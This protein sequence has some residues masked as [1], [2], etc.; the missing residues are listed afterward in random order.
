MLQVMKSKHPITCSMV[1]TFVLVV[2]AGWAS[3]ATQP[4]G[5][6][7]QPVPMEEYPIYDEVIRNKFLTSHTR[8][9]IIQRLTV[10][11][12]RPFQTHAPDR[13]FIQENVGFSN[14]LEPDLIADFLLKITRPS[15]LQGRF[16]FG[17]PVRFAT[18][19]QL[20]GPEVSLRPIPVQALPPQGVPDPPHT[21]GVLEFSRV[22]FDRTETQALVYVGVDRIDET[23]A[24][25]LIWLQ[26]AGHAWSVID[27]E[28]L[29]IRR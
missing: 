8:L 12:L 29:W 10:T 11:K 9:V 16:G 13:R 28:I 15:R 7:S 2:S 4:K 26:G 25:F 21:V 1:A 20:E 22:G 17:V 14:F 27:T 5:E 23:G 3:A 6:D 18:G 19:H 24:G